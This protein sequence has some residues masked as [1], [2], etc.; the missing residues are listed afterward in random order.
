MF[1]EDEDSMERPE[2][3]ARATLVDVVTVDMGFV[4]QDDYYY[5]PET[6]MTPGQWQQLREPLYQPQIGRYRNFILSAALEPS[7]ADLIRY[8]QDVLRCASAHRQDIGKKRHYFWLRP[9]IFAPGEFHVTFP[10][11]DTWKEATGMLTALAAGGDGLLFEDM[12]QSWAFQAFGEGER[13][14]LRHSDPD[15]DKEH[16][17]VSCDQAPVARQVREVRR[18]MARVLPELCAAVGQ[19]YWSRK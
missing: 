3:V 9:L 12:D 5:G 4:I 17:I 6:G 19:D 7:A 1:G 15:A 14:F 18:R 11:Y 16:V 13:L 2:W 10:W 8:Y